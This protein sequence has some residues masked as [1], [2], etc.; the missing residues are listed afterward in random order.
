M[1]FLQSFFLFH[2]AFERG[3]VPAAELL[4]RTLRVSPCSVKTLT[5]L[6]KK[7]LNIDKA[8]V[9]EFFASLQTRYGAHENKKT[10]F[11]AVLIFVENIGVE[12]MTSC[13]P[14]K[15]SSQLS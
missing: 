3:G 14:C 12:P 6:H 15:R 11:R 4:R 8:P 7:T 9:P 1:R 13:M 2:Y 10:A 5:E